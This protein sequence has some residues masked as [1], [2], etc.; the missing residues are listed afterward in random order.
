M[1]AQFNNLPNEEEV[2]I[3]RNDFFSGMMMLVKKL[4]ML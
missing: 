2:Q 1:E 3:Y 4:F